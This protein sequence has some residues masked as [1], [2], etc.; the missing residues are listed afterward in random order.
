MPKPQRKSLIERLKL[1][2]RDNP[3]AVEKEIHDAMWEQVDVSTPDTR[4]LFEYWF[5][6]HYRRFLVFQQGPAATVLIEERQ[7]RRAD[8][9]R[10]V[11]KIV[12]R[13]KDVAAIILMDLVGSNG[14]ANRDCTREEQF[15]EAEWRNS[16]E[17]P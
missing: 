7:Q 4:E 16:I 2:I 14:K 8:D 6:N 10:A 5:A 17:K 15:A 13:A 12:D 11:Q 3:T 1:L 9:H